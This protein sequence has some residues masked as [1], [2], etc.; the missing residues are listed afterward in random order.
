MPPSSKNPF[1]KYAGALPAFSSLREINRWIRSLRDEEID[2]APGTAGS[3]AKKTSAE[4]S[5]SALTHS[6]L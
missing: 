5:G 6:S 2:T 4:S 3:T 1:E